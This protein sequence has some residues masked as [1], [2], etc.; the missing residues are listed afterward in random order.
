MNNLLTLKRKSRRKEVT[1]NSIEDPQRLRLITPV[2]AITILIIFLGGGTYAAA[3]SHGVAP[4]DIDL[5]A[6]SGGLPLDLTATKAQATE[7][8]VTFYWIG[9]TK[10]KKFSTEVTRPGQATL[11][12]LSDEATMA[13]VGVPLISIQ[14]FANSDCLP[15][16]TCF[17]GSDSIFRRIP[18]HRATRNAD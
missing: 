12:Y 13:N 4:R 1:F 18:S 14:A 11:N 5:L 17:T 9:D 15:H 6:N 2:T 10:G 8:A 7:H 3:A 16:W